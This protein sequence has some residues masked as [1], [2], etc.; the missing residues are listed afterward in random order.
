VQPFRA[1]IIAAG[2]ESGQDSIV[3]ILTFRVPKRRTL[4]AAI[5][6]ICNSHRAGAQGPDC[7]MMARRLIAAWHFP[8]SAS[9]V[10]LFH[11][12]KGIP[13]S[14]QPVSDLLL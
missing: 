3:R 2:S 8:S 11:V 12:V 6:A 13:C 1:H 4:R 5:T 7:E 14:A 10:P 9:L